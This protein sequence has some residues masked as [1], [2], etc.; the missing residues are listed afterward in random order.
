MIRALLN[1]LKSSEYVKNIAVLGSGTAVAQAISILTA[2]ILYR[3]YNKVD[4]GTLGLYMATLGVVGVFS[5]MQYTQAI[6]IEKEE[7]KARVV[8]SLN[9]I[10][11]V[12]FTLI[13]IVVVALGK[14]YLGLWLGNPGVVPWLWLLPLSI[15][16]LGQNQILRVWA[17]R[18]KEYRMLSFNSILLSVTI[19]VL[20]ISIGLLSD[21][22]RGLFAGLLA[23]HILPPL[24]LLYRMRKS[25]QLFAFPEMD[26]IVDTA[27]RY[28]N[29]PKYSLPSEF[30]NRF[31]NQLPVFMIS[32][33]SGPAMVGVYN[34]CVRM[35]GLP[36]QLVS[37][38]VS[39]VF[40]QKANEQYHM[41]GNCKKL[42][43]QTLKS[44]VVISLVPFIVVLL[45]GPLLFSWVFGEEW[46]LAGSFAQ[47]LSVLYLLR[48]IVSPL[49]YMYII[50]ESLG[51]DLFWH[52][53]MF[54]SSFAIFYICYYYGLSDVLVLSAFSLSYVIIYFIYLF[55]SY[56]MSHGNG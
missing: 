22:P 3:I 44:L 28:S 31:S 37:S 55:R 21:G 17:N 2:P 15:F 23:S 56:R 4:Y 52:I 45:F 19:P 10:I 30:L 51:E 25:I 43:L 11:N 12:L 18:Q 33:F 41:Y 48:F 26:K 27:I 5:T 13:T 38:A 50:T 40:K 20:S 39:E 42:F 46:R 8:L 24:V 14:E 49:S 9:Q 32:T 53:V 34:L 16:F 6:L 54:I 36:V 47:V 7:E 29:F 35:L 1:K